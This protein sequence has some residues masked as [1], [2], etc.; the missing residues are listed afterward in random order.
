MSLKSK[1]NEAVSLVQQMTLEEKASLCSGRSFW[2]LQGIDRLDLAPVMVT[3]GPH[4]L[5]KQAGSA[6]HVGLHKSVPATCF[7]TASALA[8]SWDVALLA[9]IGEALGEQCV[10]EDVAVLL[11]PGVNIKRHPLCGRNFEYFSEDPL[12]AGEMAAALIQGVQSQG[13]GTSI[14]HYAVNN[15]EFG[16]MTIDVVIDERTMREI[17]LPAF[18]IAVKKAQPWTVMCAYNRVNGVYCAEHEHLLNHILRDEWG[19]EGLVVSD[20]G[21]T[22]N[23]ADGV[24]NGMDLEMPGGSGHNDRKVAQAVRNGNLA[25]ATLDQV[26][27]RVTS[28]SL[29]GA[30][31]VNQSVPLDQVA[32]HR[33]ARQ[34]SSECSVLLKNEDHA[35]PLK[36]GADFCVIGAFAKRPR[37]QGTGSSQVNPTFLD[38]AA[39]ALLELSG[40]TEL[41]YAPGYD[42]KSDEQNTQLID[43]AAALAAKHSFAL[44]FIGLPTIYESE[45]FD[46]SHMR[47]PE[48]HN[49]LVQQVCAANPQTIVVLSNGSPVEMPWVDQPKAI[50][51]TYLG[52]QAGGSATADLLFG[53]VNPSGKLAETF[54]ITVTDASSDP[55]FPGGQGRQVQ[56][57]EG[58]YVGYRYYDSFDLPVLFPFGHGLSYTTFEYDNLDAVTSWSAGE[59]SPTVRLAVTNSGEAGGAEVIQVY[60]APLSPSVYQPRQ[61]LAG[62]SKIPLQRGEIGEV[63]IQ[64]D[65]R[66]FSYFDVGTRQWQVDTGDYELRVRASS[67]DIRL[68]QIIH[69]QS[70]DQPSA[71]AKIAGPRFHTDQ[72]R[73]TEDDEVFE[74]MLNHPIP[75]PESTTPYH[76][77]STLSEVAGSRLGRAFKN[78]AMRQ[79]LKQLGKMN[80]PTLELM[81]EEMAKSMPLRSLSLLSGPGNKGV[82]PDQVEAMIDL[83]NGNYWRGLRK[84]LSARK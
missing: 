64:L 40:Q 77:N 73:L 29:L 52:G 19:F 34:A 80:D 67:R 17:Y 36:A 75:P 24:Q 79:Y 49:L 43:E 44:V 81:F 31:V 74:G 22:N 16:R 7:P 48:Q 28:L 62:F 53:R 60:V 54:P 45:G 69:V 13:V 55:W 12:L 1:H 20:W 83:F 38:T 57:R 15:Q 23:R 21:A 47:L 82:S 41:A 35:L 30:D 42:P 65:S 5:R 39:E 70:K 63:S 56:Y 72:R 51:E 6:D 3:D 37:Y 78:F 61:R 46:R 76:M 11:G 25:E 10:A 50:L 71:A 66:A 8:S 18:E 2:Y 9:R 33:L 27:T 68:S 4:G 26:A 14:K 58:V 59:T 84:Y 32:H